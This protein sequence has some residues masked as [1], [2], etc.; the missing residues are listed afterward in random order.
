MTT[1]TPGQVVFTSALRDYGSH[2]SLFE[3]Y[4]QLTVLDITAIYI[5]MPVLKQQLLSKLTEDGHM[6]LVFSTTDCEAN[7]LDL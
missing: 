6:W 4:V 5:S 3:H 7:S 2:F 1:N